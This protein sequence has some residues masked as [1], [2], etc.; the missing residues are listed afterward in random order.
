MAS[1]SAAAKFRRR[2]SSSLEGEGEAGKERE[3]EKDK[4][5]EGEREV[6]PVHR[7][8]DNS[9]FDARYRLGRRLGEGAF[10]QVRRLA[11]G[12]GGRGGEGRGGKVC[13]V[14]VCE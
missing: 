7:A 4:E 14:C 11:A 8:A 6:A 10:G 13:G 5:R 2:L 9:A 12:E 1:E 3:K